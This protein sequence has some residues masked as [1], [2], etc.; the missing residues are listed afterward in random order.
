MLPLDDDNAQ[1]DAFE[2][3]ESFRKRLEDTN[4]EHLKELESDFFSKCKSRESPDK[5]LDELSTPID[6]KC[7][8]EVV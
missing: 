8:Y 4:L 2:T 3:K 1:D 7:L 6:L 5:Y